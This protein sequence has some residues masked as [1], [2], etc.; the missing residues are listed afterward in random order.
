MFH[1]EPIKKPSTIN[2]V[3]YVHGYVVQNVVFGRFERCVL[4]TPA[5]LIGI[6]G[7]LMK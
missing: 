4:F 3:F 1:A 6:A 2:I 7:R 5:V